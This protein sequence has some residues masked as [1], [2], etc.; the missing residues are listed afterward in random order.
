MHQSGLKQYGRLRSVVAQCARQRQGAGKTAQ[1]SLLPLRRRLSHSAR[2]SRVFRWRGIVGD[3]GTP[4]ILLRAI[5]RSS[6]C[7]GASSPSKSSRSAERRGAFGARDRL[8]PVP[9]RARRAPA[10]IAQRKARAGVARRLIVRAQ[11]LGHA[12]R[13][14]RV[15]F[16]DGGGGQ[17]VSGGDGGGGGCFS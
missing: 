8:V 14:A 13:V 17:K 15:D 7:V 4:T 11:R 2:A 1:D 3:S 12:V 5:R 9:T 6:G 10:R 16:R